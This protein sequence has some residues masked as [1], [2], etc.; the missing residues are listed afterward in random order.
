M[1]NLKDLIVN[2]SARI[3]GTLYA[4]LSGNATTA[5]TATKL[6]SATVGN[7]TTP[8]YLNGG[9]PTALGY[10]LAKSVPANAVFT[11]HTYTTFVKSGTG[12]AAGLVPAPSTTAGT[13]KYLREDGTWV[14][15]TNTTYTAG[16][17]LSLSGTQFKHTNSVTAGTVGTSTASSGSTLT[18]PYVTYD[19]QGHVTATGTRT[20]T[21]SGFATT[22][23]KNTA[24][25][26]NKTGTKM[27]IAAATSQGANP[28]TYSNSNCYIGTDNC[29]YS[30]GTKVLTAAPNIASNKVTSLTGYTIATQAAALSTSD[31]LN[32]ALGKLEYKANQA[33][34]GTITVGQLAG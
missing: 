12:A 19:A 26:T 22:D 14:V 4:D 2:G 5:T 29:L 16:S 13:T 25:T 7:T 27:F 15:P 33:A 31:T 24:G 11:D 23:T 30:N 17:G 32:V 10:T 9:T 18:V 6:G 20:H 8:I 3:L 28:Q 21:I 1:A 34:S